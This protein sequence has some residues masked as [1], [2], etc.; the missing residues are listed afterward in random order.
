M[1]M[2][3]GNAASAVRPQR[4]TRRV[5]ATRQQLS[6]ESLPV[7]RV[8]ERKHFLIQRFNATRLMGH[9]ANSQPSNDGGSTGRHGSKAAHALIVAYIGQAN[10]AST[11]AKHGWVYPKEASRE[12]TSR[13][14]PGGN[15]FPNATLVHHCIVGLVHDTCYFPVSRATFGCWD[16]IS[17]ESYM[18]PAGQRSCCLHTASPLPGRP[19]RS[20]Q[21]RDQR[22]MG[23]P[24]QR[25]GTT[26]ATSEMGVFI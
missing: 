17:H 5:S 25:L 1:P 3:R 16:R 8:L 10:R 14:S 15:N 7:C 18:R 12:A 13:V 24:R 21:S 23:Q 22:P 19:R 9:G 2:Q 6:E 20:A 11:R 4:N 26:R